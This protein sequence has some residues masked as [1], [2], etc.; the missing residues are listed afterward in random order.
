MSCG[1]SIAL[2]GLIVRERSE[3]AAN[4]TRRDNTSAAWLDQI[5]A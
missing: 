2:C 3:E 4:P 1:I 5:E